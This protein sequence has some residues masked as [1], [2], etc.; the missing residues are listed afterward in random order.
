MLLLV[1]GIVITA[2]LISGAHVVQGLILDDW[3]G[4]H[5]YNRFFQ[6]PIFAAIGFSIGLIILA[7]LWSINKVLIIDSVDCFKIGLVLGC[8]G[9]SS[10]IHPYVNSKHTD[11]IIILLVF[12][13]S[14]SIAIKYYFKSKRSMG[15]T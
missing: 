4:V 1:F 15:S 10:L 11:W 12:I 9:I 14:L 13:V 8:V 5:P 7:I 2:S 3:S 6:F